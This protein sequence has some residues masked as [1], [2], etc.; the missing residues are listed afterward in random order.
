MEMRSTGI[1]RMALY[2]SIWIYSWWAVGE[3]SLLSI[4]KESD[5]VGFLHGDPFNIEIRPNC[6]AVLA[7]LRHGITEAYGS[8]TGSL[9]IHNDE[10]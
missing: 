6:E 3:S 7:R 4:R 2:R 1:H 10:R 8:H 9:S 5:E